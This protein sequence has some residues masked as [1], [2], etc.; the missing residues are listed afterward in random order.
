MNE[1]T[2]TAVMP[3]AKKALKGVLG[4]LTVLGVLKLAGLA[5]NHLDSVNAEAAAK[6]G[7]KERANEALVHAKAA[8]QVVELYF[9]TNSSFP[10][11]LT[12]AEFERPL[13]EPVQSI[14]IGANG[15]LRVV[16]MGRGPQE[17]RSFR[18]VPVVDSA[19]RFTWSCE[20]EEMPPDILPQECSR[21]MNG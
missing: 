14:R 9:K 10:I 20:L 6:R 8:A 12:A 1:S 2:N 19:G 17:K 15:A 5:M 4:V 21:S 13:P 18:Y 3:K 16:L 11:S 7:A